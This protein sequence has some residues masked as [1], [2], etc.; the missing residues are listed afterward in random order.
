MGGTTRKVIR[1]KMILADSHSPW[2]TKR[3]DWSNNNNNNQGPVDR[4]GRKMVIPTL[5]A[6][7][8]RDRRKG[9][10]IASV[11]GK[12]MSKSGESGDEFLIVRP[13]ILQSRRALTPLPNHHLVNPAMNSQLCENYV[14]LRSKRAPIPQ[15][16][17]W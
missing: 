15:I 6:W 12:K 3:F 17:M 11:V 1:P 10:P 4:R 8:L 5:Q 2:S 9:D 13:L 16:T 7:A 14:F